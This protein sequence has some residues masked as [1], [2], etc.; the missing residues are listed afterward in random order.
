VRRALL[1]LNLLALTFFLAA[2]PLSYRWEAAVSRPLGKSDLFL[3]VSTGRVIIWWSSNATPAWANI[4]DARTYKLSQGLAQ[5]Y[6]RRTRRLLGFAFGAGTSS[7]KIRYCI[8]V[9]P[10]WAP[11]TLLAL[12]PLWLW[13]RRR[14][15]TARGFEIRL[16][17]PPVAPAKSNVP[18][19]SR[20]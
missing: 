9:F 8:F 2:W 4:F 13:R 12:L 5:E 6:D 19:G 7:A 14:R 20:R 15:E 16:S 10:F 3:G 18:N 11:A 1:I 17:E